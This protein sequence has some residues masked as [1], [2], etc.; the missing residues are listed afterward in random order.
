MFPR[1]KRITD[2]N[3]FN[4]IFKKGRAF[5]SDLFFIKT[6]KN[7]LGHNRYGFVVSKKVSNKAVV[8]NKIKRR[9][10]EV[11]RLSQNKPEGN[12]DIIIYAKPSIKNADFAK[13]REDFEKIINNF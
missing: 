9:L 13:I 6:L 1:K 7:E 8:R 3:D 11:A 12:L 4:M 5:H 10:R 2:K